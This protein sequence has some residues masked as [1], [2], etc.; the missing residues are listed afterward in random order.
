[1]HV[2]QFVKER[3]HSIPFRWIGSFISVANAE[4]FAPRCKRGVVGS[5]ALLYF[6][7]DYKSA[8]SGEI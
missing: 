4:P 8:P 2:N 6:D 3:P 1:M 5:L 7:T